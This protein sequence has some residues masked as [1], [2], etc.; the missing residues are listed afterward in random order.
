MLNGVLQSSRRMGAVNGVLNCEFPQNIAQLAIPTGQISSDSMFPNLL[1]VNRNHTGLNCIR[2]QRRKSISK[3][4]KDIVG[5][6]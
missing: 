1:F 3:P 2:T 5:R 6:L 4:S